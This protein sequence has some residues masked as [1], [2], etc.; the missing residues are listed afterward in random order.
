MTNGNVPDRL[1]RLFLERLNV[2]VASADTDLFET[3]VLDSLGFVD[4][5]AGVEREF[6]IRIAVAEIDL[7][8]FRSLAKIAAFIGG[9]LMGIPPGA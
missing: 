5:L 8:H 2:E 3:G 4:L 1:H 9:Q 7:D 6:Q